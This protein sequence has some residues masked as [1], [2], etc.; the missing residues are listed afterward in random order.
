MKKF[1]KAIV[2]GKYEK[3]EA[4]MA[5]LRRLTESEERMVETLTFSTVSSNTT[6]LDGIDINVGEM[7]AQLSSMDLGVKGN[8]ASC[9][10]IPIKFAFCYA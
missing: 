1:F 7:R 9:T 8:R 2:L 3:I 10:T 5:T 4:E 6:T